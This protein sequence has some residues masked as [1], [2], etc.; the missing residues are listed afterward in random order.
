VADYKSV[1]ESLRELREMAQMSTYQ[2]AERLGWSQSKVTR[3]ER[4]RTPPDPQD[5][6]AWADAT[7]APAAVAE[8]LVRLAEAQAN[9]MR[10]WREVH[11]E[12]IAARQ[13]QMHEI[14]E[15]MTKLCEFRLGSVPGLLQ[16]P[17]Y[18]TRNLELADIT[19]RRNIPEAVAVRMNNQAILY[20][21]T[22]RF[23][24]ILTEGVLRF[25]MGG[26]EVMRA[27]AEKII[28]VMTLPNVSVSVIPFSA[29]P[30]A[31]FQSG[32]VIYEIPDA[33]MVLIEVLSV[34]QQLRSAWDLRVYRETFERLQSSAVTD[35]DAREMIRSI[36]GA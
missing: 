29:E 34:E 2:L 16:T 35:D 8:S 27:Q 22:R 11:G 32:F 31:L 15:S 14:H 19:G 13:R 3:M 4:G 12:G 28:S 23:E 5:V 1:A 10:S 24:Y 17:A 36:M 6:A 25:R 7:H 30:Q 18:A 33:P 26:P 20:D 9:Q 21:E